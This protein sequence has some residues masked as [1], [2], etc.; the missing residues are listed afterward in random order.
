M[1]PYQHG[2]SCIRFFE[3]FLSNSFFNFW[4]YK[5]VFGKPYRQNP[6]LNLTNGFSGWLYQHI[7][8][9]PT[10]GFYWVWLH[11][12]VFWWFLPMES[13]FVPTKGFWD[14]TLPIVLGWNLTN[15]FLVWIYQQ[16]LDG[17]YKWI[18][19]CTYQGFWIWP[20]QQIFLETYQHVLG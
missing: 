2:L 15:R 7:C 6:I 12:R 20:R 17:A 18:F 4:P 11:Q 10:N 1:V 3:F 16:F 13:D 19:P 9:V 8:E 5:W 14:L